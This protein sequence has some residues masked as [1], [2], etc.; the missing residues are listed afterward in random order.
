VNHGRRTCGEGRGGEAV[1]TIEVK[2]PSCGEMV[3]GE[4]LVRRVRIQ[5]HYY[6]LLSTLGACPASGETVPI[7]KK[8]TE[9]T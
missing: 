9:K 6:G 4:K 3:R 1:K 5:S 7:P 8:D 2:C